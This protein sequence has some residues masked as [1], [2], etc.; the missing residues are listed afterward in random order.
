SL[1][2]QYVELISNI[3][4]YHFRIFLLS[5]YLAKK[6][7]N[8]C[9]LFNL[10]VQYYEFRTNYQKNYFID[11][12]TV[13]IFLIYPIKLACSVT[14]YCNKIFSALSSCLS[15]KILNEFLPLTVKATF[16]TLLSSSEC[17]LVRNFFSTSLST[18]LVKVL[19]GEFKFSDISVILTLVCWPTNTTTCISF[20]L[21]PPQISE[22]ASDSPFTAFT[23]LNIEVTN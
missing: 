5:K 15:K 18:T 23:N 20:S 8:R 10:K 1:A 6:N 7:Q 9:F 22:H 14:L 21:N 11:S 19:N 3:M 2:N 17:T 16:T 4:Y 12:I 13:V